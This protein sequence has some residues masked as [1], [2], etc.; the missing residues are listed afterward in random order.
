MEAK[1]LAER[2]R[3][4]CHAP[5][6]LVGFG[7]L[8]ADWLLDPVKRPEG[9]ALAE[10]RSLRH[11]QAVVVVDAQDG[12]RADSFAHPGHTL[13]GADQRAPGF[14]AARLVRMA[15][16]ARQADAGPAGLQA[17]LR[18]F[19]DAADLVGADG[20]KGVNEVAVLA[21]EQLPDRH[22]ERL[23]LDVVQRDVDCG[24]G[25]G[26]DAPALE[27]LAAVHLLPQRADIGRVAAD[28]P[29]AIVLDGAG[30]G[31]LAAGETGFAPALEAGIGDH[32]DEELGPS[33][34]PDGETVDGCDLHVRSLSTFILSIAGY[35]G[36][37]AL[38]IDKNCF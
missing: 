4:R 2:E 28:Q 37:P 3:D 13:G 20:R 22:A 10:R 31:A 7:R 38:T 24:D 12:L 17:A 11:G 19:H 5:Q 33:P 15:L 30:N 36:G 32:P 14:E 1:L 29:T 6:R 27:I 26:E 25:G 16:H 9:H 21:A 18:E 8:V 23:A 34:N 35:R